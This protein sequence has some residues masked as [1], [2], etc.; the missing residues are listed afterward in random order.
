MDKVIRI[1]TWTV[2]GVGFILVVLVSLLASLTGVAAAQPPAS[3]STRSK[4][5]VNV[6]QDDAELL[7]EGKPTRT[8]GKNREYD[9]PDLE[10]GKKYLYEV[11]VVWKPNKFTT[12]TRTR[13][14]KFVAGEEVTVDLTTPQPTDTAD[15]LL[16]PATDDVL[17]ELVATAKIT[18]TDVVFEPKSADAR[19]LVAAVLA[20]AK[21]AVG[22]Q[23]DPDKVKAARERVKKAELEG[24]IDIQQLDPAE[25]KDYPEAT[26]VFLYAGE[27]GNLALRS[28]LLAELKPGTRIVSYRFGM[29]DWKPTDTRKGTNADGEEYQI[30]TWV[31]TDD[32]KKKFGKK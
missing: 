32:D 19:M 28:V 12:L 3:P 31:V 26:V 10:P 30:F 5:K 25:C 15:V 7:I 21:R 20:G 22:V 29:G 6:P 24:R 23:F 11:K 8:A 27:E 13:V 16:K 17:N 2:F 18:P 4:V 14:V 1:L 9:T